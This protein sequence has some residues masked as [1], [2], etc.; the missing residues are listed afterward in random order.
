MVIWIGQPD[1]CGRETGGDAGGRRIHAKRGG[2]GG[3]RTP[4]AGGEALGS[5]L[6]RGAFG[7]SVISATTAPP[8]SPRSRRKILRGAAHRATPSSTPA[9]DGDDSNSDLTRESQ[10]PSVRRCGAQA[11]SWVGER[12]PS[13]HT[14][15][16][17]HGGLARRVFA[18]E[19]TTRRPI[20]QAPRVSSM[21]LSSSGCGLSHRV[22]V[23]PGPVGAPASSSA[24]TSTSGPSGVLVTGVSVGATGVVNAMRSGNS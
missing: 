11:L 16:R 17:D 6:A 23:Q 20:A 13:Q 2:T 12:V 19:Y 14:R 4:D 22:T 5:D 9:P 15:A 3:R 8:R 21:Q 24:T 10:R 1:Q 18:P 7:T